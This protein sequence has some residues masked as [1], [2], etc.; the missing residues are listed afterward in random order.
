MDGRRAVMWSVNKALG[1]MDLSVIKEVFVD[2]TCNTNYS[3]AELYGI[4]GETV[5]MTVP[6]FYMLFEIPRGRKTMEGIRT[7][8]CTEFFEFSASY[9]LSPIFVHLDH[10]AGEILAAKRSWP[11]CTISLCVWHVLQA[12]KRRLQDADEEPHPSSRAEIDYTPNASWEDFSADGRL[13][14]IDLDLVKRHHEEAWKIYS[15]GHIHQAATDRKRKTKQPTCADDKARDE[16]LSLIRRHM[17]YHPIKNSMGQY[18]HQR[19]AIWRAQTMECWDVCKRWKNFYVWEY[20]WLN[21]YRPSKW[22]DWARSVNLNYYPI[23]QT[24]A[25]VEGHWSELKRGVLKNHNRPPL[26]YLGFIL[27]TVYIEKKL[28]KLT[29]IRNF[30]ER[31][32][33]HTELGSVWR[34]HQETLQNQQESEK[35]DQDPTGSSIERY[36]TDTSQ[37]ICACESYAKSTYNVCKHL[38]QLHSEFPSASQVVRQSTRPLLWIQGLHG[39]EQRTNFA[40]NRAETDEF[41][42]MRHTIIVHEDSNS[43]TEELSTLERDREKMQRVEYLMRAMKEGY[44]ALKHVHENY[45]PGHPH[46]WEIPPADEQCYGKWVTY[47]RKKAEIDRKRVRTPTWGQLREGFR[48]YSINK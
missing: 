11:D 29:L 37:W 17:L 44:E 5:G 28:R 27:V 4:I 47:A 2:A 23:I 25:P 40:D 48:Y 7:Q 3:G 41:D 12:I 20:L 6:L 22:M 35:N 14:F 42:H 46:L 8:V 26:D 45:E 43:T 9:G 32:S 1:V 39:K 15:Q 33:W 38:I 19:A 30:R 18:G 21:Y 34:E 31:P 36:G 13:P 16:F 10:S 24:N